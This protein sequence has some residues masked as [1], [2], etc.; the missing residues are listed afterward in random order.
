MSAASMGDV[1]VLVFVVIS[2]RQENGTLFFDE[3]DQSK[4]T[5]KSVI[6]VFPTKGEQDYF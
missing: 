2:F 6:R 1:F 3:S 5:I 4:K